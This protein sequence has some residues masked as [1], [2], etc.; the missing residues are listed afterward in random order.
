MRWNDIEYERYI[1]Y[2][3]ELNR[4]KTNLENNNDDSKA[5]FHTPIFVMVGVLILITVFEIW[6]IE[7]VKKYLSKKFQGKIE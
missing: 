1:K 5:N 7:Y 2:K 4:Y 6:T 3:E